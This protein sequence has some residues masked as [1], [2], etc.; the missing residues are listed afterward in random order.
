L[1]HSAHGAA[2]GEPLGEWLD[3]VGVDEV[4]AEVQRLDAVPGPQ[5]VGDRAGTGAAESVRTEQQV[6]HN[7][8]VDGGACQPRGHD[9]HDALLAQVQPPVELHR[10]AREHLDRAR[11]GARPGESVQQGVGLGRIGESP[12]GMG[13]RRASYGRRLGHQ[14]ALR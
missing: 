5:R 1:S 9:R 14:S 13:D 10:P 11:G 6:A 12:L 7:H 3:A 4:V 8:G 2:A